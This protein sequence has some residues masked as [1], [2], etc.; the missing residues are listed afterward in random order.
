MVSNSVKIIK[1]IRRSRQA[2]K[3][4]DFQRSV[5]DGLSYPDQLKLREQWLKEEKESGFPDAEYIAT[6]EKSVA[7]TKKLN[8][9]NK[10]RSKYTET[11]QDLTTGKINHSEYLDTLKNQ[12]ENVTDPELRLEIQGD[13][14]D[15]TKELKRYDQAILSNKVALADKDGTVEVIEEAISRVTAARAS[16]AINENEEETL[17]YDETLNALNSRLNTVKIED[18]ISNFQVKSATLG[19][20]PVEKLDFINGQIQSADETNPFRV[21]DKTYNSAKEYWNLQRDQYLAGQSEILGGNFF[22]ELNVYTDGQIAKDNAKFGYTTQQALDDVQNQYNQLSGR[23]EMTPFLATLEGTR[24][25]SMNGAVMASPGSVSV[26]T[27]RT[28]NSPTPSPALTPPA[29]A[30]PAAE[31]PE[32]TPAAPQPGTPPAAAGESA[33]IGP[34]GAPQ[35]S[36]ASGIG[37]K[38]PDGKFIFTDQGWKATPVGAAGAETAPQYSPIGGNGTISPDG[39]FV[40]KE[41]S[42]WEPV[43][44]STPT[45][46]VSL[47][48]AQPVPIAPQPAVSIPAQPPVNVPQAGPT[49]TSTPPNYSPATGVGTVSDDGKFKFTLKGWEP[50]LAPI[51]IKPP[52]LNLANPLVALQNFFAP[53]KTPAKTT[54]PAAAPAIPVAPAAPA[55]PAPKALPKSTYTGSSV[56]DYLKSI[57]EDT[58]AANRARLARERG[59]VQSDDEYLKSVKVGNNATFNTRLLDSL[60]KG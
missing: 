34:E 54:T 53:K 16:A 41:G 27:P 37:T 33:T 44:A 9:F 14:L 22:E 42:G 51:A 11:L 25:S 6:L 43:T 13:I 59:I 21:G 60:R 46:Q 30:A 4:A 56:V 18:K 23:A 7:D 39:K 36:P 19:V 12:L 48:E 45:T 40:F 2:K 28:V 35:S 15:A 26:P 38:S 49:P 17:A 57:G 55:A 8:R 58:S 10:Y 3:E 31:T 52:S 32:E 1:S 29:S 24:T 20:S 47:P 5:A 50:V